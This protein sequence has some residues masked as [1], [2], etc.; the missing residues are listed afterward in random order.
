MSRDSN[1]KKSALLGMP[2]GTAQ[3]R[4]RKNILFHFLKKHGENYCFKCG[5]IIESSEDLSIE[6]KKAWQSG[7]SADLFWDMEN[8]AFSHLFCNRPEVNAGGATPFVRP[9]GTNWCVPG[10][11][12]A[13]VSDFYKNADEY[14]GLQHW[15]KSHRYKR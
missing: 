13:P 9:E 14:L 7:G 1:A 2:H 3:H 11:H 12:F 4:L 15:C 8:I 10:Q 5:K 6:H